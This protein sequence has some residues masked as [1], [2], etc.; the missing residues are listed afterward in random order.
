MGVVFMTLMVM[1]LMGCGTGESGSQSAYPKVSEIKAQW[2]AA[3]RLQIENFRAKPGRK[4]EIND[5]KTIEHLVTLIDEKAEVEPLRGK[6]GAG[7]YVVIKILAKGDSKSPVRELTVVGNLCM[8]Q[9]GKKV[10]C[11]QLPSDELYRRL[12]DQDLADEKPKPID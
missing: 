3:E 6:L 2:K 12:R 8:F 1:T 5:T 11:F 4:Y 7:N 10:F 9:E